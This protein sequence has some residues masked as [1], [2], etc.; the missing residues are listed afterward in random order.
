[1]ELDLDS[2]LRSRGG[3][4]Y[5]ASSDENESSDTHRRA[6]DEI[7]KESDSDS[8]AEVLTAASYVLPEGD[9][10]IPNGEII[11]GSN[12]VYRSR[13]D[14]TL[15]EEPSSNFKW[16][17]RAIEPSS[18]SYASSSRLFSSLLSNVRPK[19]KPGAALAAAVASSRSIPTPHAAAIKSKR[20]SGESILKIL[21]PQNSTE[22]EDIEASLVPKVLAEPEFSSVASS[23]RRL[24]GNEDA[25]SS[26]L[27]NLDVAAE[28]LVQEEELCNGK[29][30]SLSVIEDETFENLEE[31]FSYPAND[32]QPSVE[33]EFKQD[34]KDL[35]DSMSSLDTDTVLNMNGDLLDVEDVDAN[36]KNVFPINEAEPVIIGTE[37][38]GFNNN[39]LSDGTS[40]SSGEES[41]ISSKMGN[42]VEIVNEMGGSEGVKNK[43]CTH[44]KPLDRAEELEKR[45]ASSGLHWE[46][47]AAAQPMRLEGIRRGPPAIGYLQMDLDNMITRSVS[48]QTFRHDYGLPHVL[49]V[50]INFIAVGTSKGI[51]LVFPSKYSPHHADIM[52]GKMLIFGSS[53]EKIT[54]P[55]TS[56]CFNQQGDLLL[57][58][59]NDGHLTIWD[60]PRGISAK[61]ITGEHNAPVTHTLFLGQ[62]SQVSRQFK[63][64]TSD[65][66]GL[67]LLHTSSVL[68]LLNHFSIKTQYLLDG[69]KN[70]TVLC[71][72]PI[73]I[74][75]SQDVG[76]TFSQVYPS[77]PSSG[78]GSKVG[79]VVGG[80][81]GWKLFN[82]N[83]SV[84][85]G[86]VVLA[87]NQN[88]LV[89]KLSPTVE[90]YE[91]LSRP[92]GVRE[93]S[94][95]YAAWKCMGHSHESSA[96]VSDKVA[97]LALA[98]D[99]KIQISR[100]IK[101]EMRKHKEW[102]LDS[103]AIGVA[104]LDDQMLVV[105]TIR[106]QLCLF[107][108]DGPELHRTN[109]TV[110]CSN[111]D[112]FILFHSHYMNTF[113]NPEKAYHTSV[114]VRGATIYILG[115][116][117]LIISRL[118]PWK[119]RIQVL[120]SAGDWMGALDMA[121][122]LYDGHAHGVLDLPRS[123][124][125]IREAIMPYLVEL[126]LS[127]VDEVFSY[128]SVAFY[129]QIDKDSLKKDPSIKNC[130]VGSD[131]EEQY[132][133]VGGV[134]VEFCVHIKR[135]DILFN[136]IF[137]KFVGVH[138]EGTFLEILEPYI[139][140]D[141]LG[142]LPPEIMQA[143][144]EYYSSKG[145]LERVEQCVLHM[146]ISSLDF[147][148]VVKLCREHGLYGALIYLFN[149][150]LN[151]FK[152]P[153]EELLLALQDRSSMDVA[154]IGYRMLVYLKYCFQGL[155]FPPGHGFLP[156]SQLPSIR[157]ELL[158]FLLEDSK[159]PV[160]Q[161]SERIKS[162][163]RNLPNLFYVLCLDSEATLDVLKCAFKEVEPIN[164][165]SVFE[166]DSLKTE[167]TLVQNTAD[168]LISILDLESDMVWSFEMDDNTDAWP[169]EKDVHFIL[170]FI[171]YIIA[172]KKVTISATV[173]RHLL[174]YL[175][176]LNLTLDKYE[177]SLKERRLLFVLTSVPQ[178]IWNY[179][180]V[181]P[182]CMESQFYQ[183]CGLIHYTKG[184]HV[185]ALDS[186]MKDLDEPIHAFSFIDKMFSQ[187]GNTEAVSFQSVVISRIP[188]LVKLSRECTFFLVIDRLGSESQNILSQ[189]HSHPQSL[190]LF[191]KTVID[192]NISGTLKFPV[193]EAAG[194]SSSPKARDSP[195]EITEYLDKISNFPKLLHHD[196]IQVTDE[197]AELYL[198]LLC[199][200]ERDSV[201]KFL[202]S[203]DNYRLENCLRLCQKYGATDAAA[204]LL[205][206]V[207]D[208]GGALELLMSGF[209]EKMDLLVSAVV[210]KFSDFSSRKFSEK[211]QLADVME[212]K[213]AL[214]V[215]DVLHASVG[216][217]QRNTQ[218]LDQRESESLW[219][220]LFDSFS[221]PL[222]RF[223]NSMEFP[224]GENNHGKMIAGSN[225]LAGSDE[226]LFGWKF[227]KYKVCGKILRRLFSQFI[228]EIMEGMA[229]YLP[230][231]AVMS[232]LLSDNR[233][234]EFGDFK[235][236]ILKMLGSYNYE[237]RIL[238]TAKSLL[239][240]DT[241]YT[242]S[243]LKNGALHAFAPRNFMCCFCG[244]PL[245]KGSS[246]SGIRV[247]N[248]G[249]AVHLHCESGE[250]EPYSTNSASGCPI[251]QHGKN[252]R[253]KSNSA[254]CEN[255]L[256]N[257]LGLITRHNRRNSSVQHLHETDLMDKS[258]ARHQMSRFDILANLQKDKSLHIDSL[259]QLRLAPPAIYHDKVLKG[260]ISSIRE[261]H[262]VT[263]KKEKS[264]KRWP[265]V[266]LKSKGAAR[267]FP[268][269]SSIFGTE[270]SKVR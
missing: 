91:N 11:A 52:D 9:I 143:L 109:L 12:A 105:L 33:S 111:M 197:M 40:C 247:F 169:L 15:E 94:M 229:G 103:T 225:I 251:C 86:V 85:E 184:E 48:S 195:I 8:S 188:E 37:V 177:T 127:Y 186:Y 34:L 182:L 233:N 257:N 29:A 163:C 7:L 220:R 108:R 30:L 155:A 263:T 234:Q 53:S 59:Y 79:G 41:R 90:I 196:T 165:P 253:E 224:E 235:M 49:A 47:G 144:V 131:I 106:G 20:A 237:R 97:W 202:V 170:D 214:A 24:E 240:D 238:D 133:S 211:D 221:V 5:S 255:G 3:E 28:E 160:P 64:V 192:F 222:K 227:S 262:E 146:D 252:P 246:S 87:T 264:S 110:D 93:G 185:A 112:G 191:L 78:L 261:P 84:V 16:G 123:V 200:F 218:R 172:S 119:E 132:A 242:M 189:L 156:P 248:C 168:A 153:L 66:K 121:M 138:H 96:D 27:S 19:G 244:L 61:V 145:W 183:A 57:V 56:M 267:R 76:S 152:A 213:E 190:F 245:A 69:Q 116:M 250:S 173:F 260:P 77:V 125:T 39:V 150:G 81:T 241:F 193:P 209:D 55:V 25:R 43:S 206:R 175:T 73:L 100:L 141:M 18:S 45:K 199:Q 10:R 154:A 180:Y 23:S 71:A 210:D 178:E 44:L 268:L 179:S 266:E 89:V 99:R 72:C 140:R 113:G 167:Y 256:V 122:R 161:V 118:L 98:W 68:P 236:T 22:D 134:A 32:A 54:G 204:F 147:N 42:L 128:I 88:A 243:V 50:H 60:V 259:P 129:S 269:R 258:H 159:I 226:P 95:P 249:H 223:D 13:V 36:A 83:S 14:E 148:Q 176:S 67:V 187:L 142:F 75:N 4:L 228:G 102:I 215:R 216:L 117:H 101:S 139:L 38:D 21:L 104:W 31:V 270:K 181:L 58:G 120:Q 65:S 137:S 136:G 92:D 17:R 198:E 70:G 82:G 124:D 115:P 208:V 51:V 219:F 26:T 201:L 164:D 1:M 62:D 114:A 203:F 126:I 46:E 254:L 149:R 107:S 157:K 231:P 232:K 166:F 2:F 174:E 217:C 6:V 63:A 130:S 194:V 230:L 74:D 239:E 205:E 135:T 151:D 158:N 35:P 265:L 207:G 171:V 212:L 162:S 80:D